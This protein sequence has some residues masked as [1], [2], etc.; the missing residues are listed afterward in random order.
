MEGVVSVFLNEK[1]Y[2]RT[3]RSWDFMGFPLDVKR[4]HLESDVIIGVIDT[5]IWPESESFSDKGFGPPPAKWKGSCDTSLNFTCNNKL[6]G[7]QYFRSDGNITMNGIASPRDTAGHGTHTASTAAGAVVKGASFQGLGKGTARG[8]VPSARIAVYKAC[9]TDSCYDADLLAAFDAAIS[10]GVDIIS[11]SVG[12][13]EGPYFEDSIAIGAFHAMKCGILTSSSAGNS[14][15]DLQTLENVAPWLLTVAASS[16]DRKFV[17]Q[18]QLGN[19][20]VVEGISLNTLDTSNT[21]SP[22]IYGGDAQNTV[23]EYQS[24]YCTEDSLDKKLVKGKIVICDTSENTGEAPFIAGAAGMIMQ[25][26]G[27]NAPDSHP[28]PASYLN[29]DDGAR[30]VVYAKK[31][32]SRPRASI[33]KSVAITD[34]LSPT[35]ASFSSRG[36]STISPGILKPD[37]SAPG[38]AILAA[39]PPIA[40]V[41]QA[42]SDPRSTQFNMVSGTSMACPH[43]SGV[44]A[45]I[46]S[47]HP[48]WS[49]AA[50][51]SALMTTATPMNS[52]ST[53]EAELAYGSGHINPLKAVKPGLVY[54]TSEDDYVNF[55]CNQ[56]L[57]ATEIRLITGKTNSCSKTHYN[58]DLNYPSMAISVNQLDFDTVFY[59][60]VT[61]VGYHKCTYHARVTTPKGQEMV[62]KVEPSVLKF[63]YVGQK[64][65]FKVRVTGVI[66]LKTLLFSASLVWDDGHHQV[67]SP[68][69]VSNLS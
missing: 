12:G 54:D 43:V 59:R 24:R 67:R 51:K 64:L 48:T 47:F 19:G 17:T 55:L 30:V 21:T 31:R 65:S 40:T 50:I 44:A 28:L 46:K 69:V 53:E 60:T 3:T 8:G 15:P 68:I 11:I 57:N 37:L 13:P 27:P 2:L 58:K 35:V 16:T 22:L 45:Y 26:S 14:G 52:T 63:K 23:S 62:I 61:N 41:S 1:K 9:W 38:I 66:G 32:D 20:M 7:A 4:S 34:P 29:V 33:L 6:I 18:V 42:S 49:P 10:D 36:P 5:G 56:G 25:D 39:Y